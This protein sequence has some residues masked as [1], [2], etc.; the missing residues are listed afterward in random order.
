MRLPPVLS[1]PNEIKPFPP[2][3]QWDIPFPYRPPPA[4]LVSRV[5]IVSGGEYMDRL[6]WLENKPVVSSNGVGQPYGE[7]LALLHI[8]VPANR[9]GLTRPFI[10]R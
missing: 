1:T 3:I 2:K 10:G 6:E 4:C 7:C 5:L 9:F 8:P